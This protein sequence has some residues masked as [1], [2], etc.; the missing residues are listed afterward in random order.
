MERSLT[1]KPNSNAAR[2]SRLYSKIDL[3]EFNSLMSKLIEEPEEGDSSDPEARQDPGGHSD[4][5]EARDNPKDGS[6]TI[7]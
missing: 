4:D 7:N 2:G 3:D 1:K 6:T 5:I